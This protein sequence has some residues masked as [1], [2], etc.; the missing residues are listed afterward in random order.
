MFAPVAKILQSKSSAITLDGVNIDSLSSE[1]LRKRVIS[2]VS[3]EP[4][5][6]S[7]TIFDNIV[8]GSDEFDVVFDGNGR[9]ESNIPKRYTDNRQSGQSGVDLRRHR[10]GFIFPRRLV[11]EDALYRA[12]KS[13]A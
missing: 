7:G 12:G 3:Q 11:S 9:N 6:F 10:V 8:Y 1:W 5:L 13:N 4:V 2:I